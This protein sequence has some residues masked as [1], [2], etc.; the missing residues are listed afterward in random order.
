MIQPTEEQYEFMVK[1]YRRKLQLMGEEPTEEKVHG[2]V[3][4]LSWNPK[5]P[6]MY[7]GRYSHDTLINDYGYNIDELK[8]GGYL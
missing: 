2:L 6:F 8:K 3:S 7:L 4:L 1:H 5:P